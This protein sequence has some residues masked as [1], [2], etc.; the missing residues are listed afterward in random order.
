MTHCADKTKK[1]RRRFRR[2]EIYRATSGV[3]AG[4]DVAIQAATLGRG[5]TTEIFYV[6]EVSAIGLQGTAQEIGLLG[7]I[8]LAPTNSFCAAP[9]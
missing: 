7:P 8:D 5:T 4:A 3:T 1:T 2:R 6:Q 9:G